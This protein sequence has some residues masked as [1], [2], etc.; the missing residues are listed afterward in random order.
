[1]VSPRSSAIIQQAL[2]APWKLRALYRGPCLTLIKGPASARWQRPSL[3]FYS[4]SLPVM[5]AG[6]IGHEED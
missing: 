3:G 6:P 1:M 4:A 2:S 5:N